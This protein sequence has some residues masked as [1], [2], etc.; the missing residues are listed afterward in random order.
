MKE[1]VYDNNG[2][3]HYV[4]CRSFA[5]FLKHRRLR[6]RERERERD[7]LS[8]HKKPYN[9]SWS[10]SEI[11]LAVGPLCWAHS[12]C[13]WLKPCF[14]CF[15]C[16]RASFFRWKKSGREELDRVNVFSC[17]QYR[18]CWCSKWSEREPIMFSTIREPAKV[19][20]T[21][22]NQQLPKVAFVVFSF[23]GCACFCKSEGGC[24]KKA[25]HDN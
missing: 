21:K 23:S 2:K 1:D 19:A 20:T 22:S 16:F 9:C 24:K 25:A 12:Y 7:S 8:L 4:M 11:L 14:E 18:C 3:N 15:A 5:C 17:W 6:E 13:N 10:E